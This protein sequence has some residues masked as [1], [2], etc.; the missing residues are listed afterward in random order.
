MRLESGRVTR[1]P[2]CFGAHPFLISFRAFLQ[3]NNLTSQTL[4]AVLHTHSL[5]AGL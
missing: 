5:Q 1:T 4:A 3:V 2:V